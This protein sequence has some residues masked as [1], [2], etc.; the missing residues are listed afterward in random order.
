MHTIKCIV[1]TI[2]NQLCA[3]FNT[4]T[5]LSRGQSI[6][7][8][9]KNINLFDQKIMKNYY[10]HKYSPNR[11]SE[12]RLQTIFPLAIYQI[13]VVYF[14]VLYFIFTEKNDFFIFIRKSF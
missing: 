2:N 13:G 4:R 9:Y 8:E 3:K 11:S 5:T 14:H 12:E 10:T 6:R 1:H 7:I